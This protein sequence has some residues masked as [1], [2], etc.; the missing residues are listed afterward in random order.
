MTKLYD[1]TFAADPLDRER[2]D[3]LGRRLAALAGFVGPAHLEV[4][5]SLQVGGRR[6]RGGGRTREQGARGGHGRRE[7]G[8]RSSSREEGRGK[9]HGRGRGEGLGPQAGAWV[10]HA[11]CGMRC[12][13]DAALHLGAA[14]RR[15]TAL[16]LPPRPAGWAGPSGGGRRGATGGGAE[17]APA[18]VA[19]QGGEGRGSGW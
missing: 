4:S 3:V 12:M 15:L 13:R 14:C 10:L 19:V 18:H 11:A 2:D 1:R 8:P 5:A 17:G 9:A 6:G 16:V 7:E